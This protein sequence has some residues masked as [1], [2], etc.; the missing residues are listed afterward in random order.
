MDPSATAQPRPQDIPPEVAARIVRAI[1]KSPSTFVVL[2]DRDLRFE[3]V[4]RALEADFGVDPDDRRGTSALERIHPGDIDRLLEGI[5][6]LA[7]HVGEK[8][9]VSEPIRYRFHRVDGTWVVMEATVHSLLD[10]PHVEGMLIFTRQVTGDTRP[11]SSTLD[12][13]VSDM[14][15]TD[16]LAAMAGMVPTTIGTAALVALLDGHVETGAPPGSPVAELVQDHRWWADA[17]RRA[18]S[19]WPVDFAGLPDDLA[20]AGRNAGYASAWSI[21]VRDRATGEMI[22]CIIVW[23]HDGVER[24]VAIDE[25]LRRIERLAALVISEHRRHLSAKAWSQAQSWRTRPPRPI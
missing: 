6:Q 25:T 24:H 14:P 18:E 10:D 1:S 3:W 9:G 13:L 19:S 16:V 4:S 11:I 2:L 23:V 20:V 8:V 7:D 5:G 12:L 21:V 15:L 22:G 17:S